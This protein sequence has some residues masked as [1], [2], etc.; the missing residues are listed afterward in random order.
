MGGVTALMTAGDI[1]DH[2]IDKAEWVDPADTVD[3]VLLG[4][5]ATEVTRCLV[6]WMPDMEALHYAVE[7]DIRIVV[8][9]EP[10]FWIHRANEFSPRAQAKLD[11]ANEYGLTI[12]RNHDCWDRWPHI[13]ITWAWADFLGLG[14]TPHSISENKFLHRYDINPLGLAEFAEQVDGA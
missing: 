8:C 13:G 5:P 3:G 9:H 2:F 7:N 11:F 1:V 10:L 14:D 12:I 6:T 4:D